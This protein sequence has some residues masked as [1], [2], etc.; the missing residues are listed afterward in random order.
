MNHRSKRLSPTQTGLNWNHRLLGDFFRRHRE[1]AGLS[2]ADATFEADLE[3]SALLDAFE[4]GTKPIPLEFVFCLT[5]L[6]NIPP[7]ETL[8]MMFDLHGDL[9][10]MR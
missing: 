8:L 5:N 7:E 4:Q 2:L 9:S 6:Y 1:A 10:G 3:D